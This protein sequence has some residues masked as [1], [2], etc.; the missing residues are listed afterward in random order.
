[1]FARRGAQA[2]GRTALIRPSEEGF[3][4]GTGAIRAR[5]EDRNAID[6]IFLAWFLAAPSTVSWIREQAIGATMPNLNKSIIGRIE[7]PLIP[8]SDQNEIASLLGA[9]D[10]KIELNRLM[11]ATL[12]EMARAL[13]RSW[14][15][16]FDPV[17]ARAAGQPPTHM[18][19]ATAALF[20]NSFSDNGLPEGWEMSTIGKV[21][22]TVGGTT[23]K[24]K[25]PTFWDGPHR[26]ATPRDLSKLKQPILF[27]T[28]RT[29]TKAGLSKVSSGLSPAGTVLLSSR[30]PIGY[31]VIAKNP[32]AVNQG[33][34]ALRETNRISSVE[35]Y[36]WVQSNMD[37][38]LANA[39]GSTFQEISKKNFRPLPCV[40]ASDAVRASFCDLAG[41]WFDRICTLCAE[42]NTLASLRDTLLPRLMSGELRI[43][44]AEQQVESSL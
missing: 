35:A 12:E 23:P 36:F 32:V 27:E 34:I 37:E 14:F 17:H 30:A 9:L 2:T 42:A 44:D 3:I 10:D 4:C 31:I 28:E 24:T 29:L 7:F 21:A 43:R 39:N 16:D 41:T 22:E 20:P 1:M 40:V 11:S 13:Y 38:I 26:W 19:P 5:I 6:P 15:V 18:H 25:E 33:F 8:M